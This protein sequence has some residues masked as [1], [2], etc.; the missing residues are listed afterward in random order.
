[1]DKLYSCSKAAVVRDAT[2]KAL[3]ARMFQ[4]IISHSNRHLQPTH[5]FSGDCYLDIGT[6]LQGAPWG[7]G[8][9]NQVGW[10]AHLKGSWRGEFEWKGLASF[11]PSSPSLDRHH[12]VSGAKRK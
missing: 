5:S 8:A 1:M 7:A 3:Y 6:Y 9:V 10:G 11:G 2:A 4:W 12:Y